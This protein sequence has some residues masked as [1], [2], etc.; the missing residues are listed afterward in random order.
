MDSFERGPMHFDVTDRGPDGGPPVVLLHGFPA[1]RA[2][3][4]GVSAEL[5]GAGYRT[6]A[7]D[8]RGYSA[9]ARP[10]GR[11]DYS[12]AELAA[13]VVAMADAAGLDRFHLVGHDWGAVVAWDLAGRLP[14][15]VAT[16]TAVSVPHPRAFLA[17]MLRSSQ[18]LHSWYMVAF[19]LPWLPERL[20]AGRGGEGMR[21]SL[22][23]SGLRP[24]VAARYAARAADP[25]AM[26]GP[27]NWY[28]ALPFGVRRPAVAV[29]VPTALIW[30]P[31]DGFVSRAA[32][33]GSAAWAHGPYE[34]VEVPDADH[35]L[36]ENRPDVVA[37]VVADLAGRHPV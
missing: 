5:T 24:D 25:A 3:W 23:R 11:R 34:L 4:D 26:R 13:D 15:R 7:P 17:S 12:V 1:D 35:W 32:A 6:V 16:L 19:Q 9:G 2:C 22:R 10:P 37:G 33:E 31:G 14:G 20:L 8:Q 21:R 30:S 18:L 29:T 27:I 28:R 36:P